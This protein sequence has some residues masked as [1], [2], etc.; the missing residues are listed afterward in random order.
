MR[1]WRLVLALAMLCV[2]SSPVADWRDAAQARPHPAGF[3]FVDLGP[4][5]T[6][7]R[8]HKFK[9]ADKYFWLHENVLPPTPFTAHILKYSKVA[10]GETVLDLGTGCGI[11]AV[12]AADQATKVIAT[13]IDPAAVDNARENI[14]RHGVDHIVEVRQ[15]DL[16]APVRGESFDV[17]YVT[18]PFPYRHETTSNLWQLHER[19]FREAVSYLRPGGR[20]YYQA[21][22]ILFAPR[23]EEL[24]ERNGLFVASLHMEGP[25]LRRQP[26]VYEFRKKK[27]AN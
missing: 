16:F 23:L 5:G 7:P 15:G 27:T 19:F 20:I 3:E 8:V 4:Q 1:L 24:A 12:F 26:L 6:H 9:V 10:R 21:S 25:A 14:N 2:I 17:M 13:D 11:L 18:L 22:E